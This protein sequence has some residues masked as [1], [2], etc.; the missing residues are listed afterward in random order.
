[1][2]VQYTLST[3]GRVDNKQGFE[4]RLNVLGY[5]EQAIINLRSVLSIPHLPEL[6]QSIPS[7]RDKVIHAEVLRGISFPDV[8]GK[9]GL[10]IGADV[11]EAHR[12]LEY[13]INSSGGPN[14]VKTPLGWSLV[15]PTTRVQPD[16][17]LEFSI[18][19]VQIDN[20]VLHQQLQKVYDVDFVTKNERFGYEVSVD[21]RKALAATEKSVSRLKGHYQIA[22]PWKSDS[23]KLLDNKFVA[24]RR[25]ACQPKTFKADIQLHKH[26]QEKM[27]EYINLGYAHKIPKKEIEHIPGPLTLDTQGQEL[28]AVN[29]DTKVISNVIKYLMAR[30]LEHYSCFARLRNAVAC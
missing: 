11:S 26:Y 22:P 19:S 7:P 3:L 29:H 13:R 28:C 21:D 20:A 8:K 17:L 4:T 15:K 16:N 24:I 12:T 10:L 1:M 30:L 6:K 18:N 25:L 27:N 14:V 9:V 5:G 23:L 2:S